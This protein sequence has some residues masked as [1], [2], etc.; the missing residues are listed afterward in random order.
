[1]G[2]AQAVQRTSDA[3]RRKARA[4]LKADAAVAVAA[5]EE[6]LRWVVLDDDE[7]CRDDARFHDRCA[8]HTVTVDSRAGLTDADANAA[9]RILGGRV[10]TEPAE[11]AV[12]VPV[13]SQK[14]NA[15]RKEDK[16][17]LPPLG[18]SKK[19]RQRRGP[20]AELNQ[21]SVQFDV[22]SP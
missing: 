15:A 9:I 11:L 7:S 4:T 21:A 14:E 2:Q 16:G 3:K 12:I 17:C 22:T 5:E 18:T 8:P 20:V 10:N 19:S 6:L 13:P 1:M